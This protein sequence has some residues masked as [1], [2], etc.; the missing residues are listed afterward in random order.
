MARAFARCKPRFSQKLTFTPSVGATGPCAFTCCRCAMAAAARR[1][2][3]LAGY[4]ASPSG[5]L[6]VASGGERNE[7]SQ[8]PQRLRSQERVMT[9]C[10]KGA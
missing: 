2:M 8:T 7:W 9:A 1:A 3:P 4:A 5:A 6:R 10:F